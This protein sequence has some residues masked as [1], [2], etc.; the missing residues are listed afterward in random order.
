MAKV[1]QLL[2]SPVTTAVL[3]VLAVL[4]ILGSAIGGARAALG[5]DSEQ[6]LAGLDTSAIGVGLEQ[7]E[8]TVPLGGSNAADTIEFGKE[9]PEELFVKNTMEADEYVRVTI[10][11]YWEIDSAKQYD[12]D[13]AYIKLN[14]VEDGWFVD[15]SVST[16]E[17]IVM[18]STTLLP[19]GGSKQF[20][21]KL[22][23]DPRASEELLD[24]LEKSGAKDGDTDEVNFR[25]DVK[26]DAVQTHNAA[27]AIKSSWGVD[28][29]AVGING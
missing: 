15:E 18:Y 12:L 19:G 21:D 6:Y 5:P 25:I 14:L 13:P 7:K 23:I 22:T 8:V 4:L 17:R 24:A 29:N 16:D 20:A 28:M 10:Y 1:K 26:V 2:V 3:L 27:D 9:L 11:K